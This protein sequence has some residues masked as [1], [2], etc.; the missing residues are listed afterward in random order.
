MERTDIEDIIIKDCENQELTKQEYEILKTWLNQSHKNQQLYMQMK[1]TLLYPKPE[2]MKKLQ[3]EVWFHLQ[4]RMKGSVTFSENIRRINN[5]WIRIAAILLVS[6]SIGLLIFLNYNRNEEEIA[7]Y[8]EVKLIEKVSLPGQKITTTL[9]D[10]TIVKLN[11]NSKIIVPDS[12]RGDTREVSLEGEAFFE[13]VKNE[14]QPFVIK[15]KDIKVR[16]LGTSFNIKS[17]EDQ[18]SVVSVASGKVAVMD[19]DQKSVNLN[20]GEKVSFKVDSG[21]L[22]KDQFN[23]VEEY[24]WK[25]NIL[26]FKENSLSE[27][28]EKLSNWY[29]VDF[30]MQ[31]DQFD[32]SKKFSGK[33]TDPTLKA[34]LEGLSYVFEFNYH[35]NQKTIFLE[36]K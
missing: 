15:A 19:Q 4:K 31:D 6:I 2:D 26:V 25:E 7:S 28:T 17:Y 21:T 30:K 9:S 14:M 35:L 11:A 27:I 32:L 13:V 20:P 8:P 1:M 5:F 12:F 22:I 33:Y 3:K 10:G 29:G 23:W 18:E 24:G 16:V 36:I 34:V